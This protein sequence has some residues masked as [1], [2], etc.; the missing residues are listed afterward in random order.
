MLST[1]SGESKGELAASAGAEVVIDYKREAVAD[2]VLEA[3]DGAGVD[4]IVEVELGGNLETS[5]AVLKVNGVIASYASEGVPEPTLP[6]YPFL[7]KSV[8]LRHV[9][10]FQVPEDGKAD[11]VS[12]ITEWMAGDQISHQIGRRFGL[13]EVAAAH[14]AVESGTQGKVLIEL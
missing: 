5:L 2:R 12:D 10:V 1:V 3:T 13:A 8:V 4:R 6:F 14:Q 11:A 7:Y 9:L